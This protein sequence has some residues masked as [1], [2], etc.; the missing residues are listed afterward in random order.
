M[1]R[2]EQLS[3]SFPD[4]VLFQNASFLINPGQRV[5]IVG[6]NGAGKTTL[7]RLLMGLE[8]PSSGSV[9]RDRQTVIGYL[10]QEIPAGSDRTILGDVLAAFPRL[11]EL[12]SEINRL[13]MSA[14]VQTGDSAALKQLGNLQHEYEVLGGWTRETEAKAI[15]TGLGF[16]PEQL[17]QPMNT[18]SGGW[19]MRVKLAGLLLTHADFLFLDEPTNHLD[20]EAALW[21]E[22]FLTQWSGGL[23][24]ISHDRVFLDKLVSHILEVNQATVQLF[25]GNYSAYV[26]AKKEQRDHLWAAYRNQQKKIEAT[27]RFIERFR[28]KNTKASQV[29]SR[30][31][32]LEKMD[33]VVPPEEGVP[34]FRLT[35]PEPT[36]GPQVLASLNQVTKMFG[37]HTVY[38]DLNLTIERGQKL[39]LVGPNG[40]GKSTLLKL[41]AG[42]E[43][44]TEGTC[45]ITPGVQVSYYA[46]HQLDVLNP[47]ETVLDTIRKE[48]PDWSLTDCRTYLGGFLFSGDEVDKKVLVLSG[49]EKARLALA[50]MLCTPAHLLLLD[51]PT[52]HLD[53]TSRDVV[54]SALARFS[55]SIVC[56]SHD[57]HFLNT[58]TDFTGEV[59][60]GTIKLFSGNYDYYRWKKS[61]TQPSTESPIPKLSPKSPSVSLS[62]ADRKRKKNRRQ[63][64]TRLLAEAEAELETII[65][66]FDD[67]QIASDFEALQALQRRQ[68]DCEDTLLSLLEEQ[69][70]LDRD[71]SNP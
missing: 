35:L 31:K 43:H 2:A 42:V 12:E 68:K 4:R 37:T 32:Q 33:R 56:I 50:R 60:A 9:Y 14:A 47:H 59:G 55:G 46:Q 70:Q 39:S 26:K 48:V 52:N 38:S 71:L 51:E 49:G 24:L 40:A 21:L 62:Y 64:I 6:P 18:L 17:H 19:R 30:I 27:E 22:N 34:T 57:R 69:E 58:V 53:L 29:Q 13:N 66:Q 5:G 23:V 20:L 44:P 67:P 41:L 54:E 11:A 16:H 8:S 45:T 36:R 61:Q 15:L 10:P 25:T 65:R 3:K 7:L 1:I 28:Y 63:K